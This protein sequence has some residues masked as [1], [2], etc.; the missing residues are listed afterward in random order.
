L[1]ATAANAGLPHL[2][3][4]SPYKS[5]SEFTPIAAIGGN[6]QCLVVPASLPAKTLAEFASYA[7]A[8]PK[9]LLRGA[10]NVGRHGGRPRHR[11]SGIDL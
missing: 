10:N 7:K 9:P 4:A 2:S 6:T 5:I 8:S 3:K 1:F 11:R